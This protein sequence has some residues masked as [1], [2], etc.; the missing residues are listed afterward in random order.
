MSRQYRPREECAERAAERRD[1]TAVPEHPKKPCMATS[2]W[3]VAVRE[4][5]RGVARFASGM[6][7]LRHYDPSEWKSEISC[8]SLNLLQSY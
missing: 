3:H 6:S 7:A 4:P 1:W 2:G 5:V 8:Y